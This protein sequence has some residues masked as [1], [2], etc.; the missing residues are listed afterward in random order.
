MRVFVLVLDSHLDTPMR[1]DQADWDIRDRHETSAYSQVDLPRM[2]EGGL[3]LHRLDL[4]AQARAAGLT[5]QLLQTLLKPHWFQSEAVLAHARRFFADFAV[6]ADVKAVEGT[7]VEA[8]DAVGTSSVELP[9]TLDRTAPVVRIVSRSPPVLRVSEP[10]TLA[11]RVNGARR[12][13]RVTGHGAVRVPRI[14]ALRTL[15]VVA[16]DAAGNRAVLRRP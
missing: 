12:T 2:I 8:T 6:P 10:A 16:R 5:R 3:N 7:D 1:L 15:V 11:L 14:R 4:L 9:F 13:M